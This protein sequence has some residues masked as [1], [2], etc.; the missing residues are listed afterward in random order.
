[1]A[2][3]IILVIAGWLVART[4]LACSAVIVSESMAP[5]L[6]G[7]HIAVTCP[8]CKHETKVGIAEDALQNL[9]AHRPIACQNCGKLVAVPPETPILPG[10]S[11]LV[12][13]NLW[14][15]GLPQRW[16]LIACQDPESSEKIIVKRVVGLPG[17]TVQIIDG[18]VFIDGQIARKSL[19]QQAATAVLVYDADLGGT[20]PC[21][22][23]PQRWIPSL[24]N[25]A[26]S[27][28]DGN[29]FYSGS[30]S[31]T[32]ADR[33]TYH[34]QCRVGGELVAG[35]V[36]DQLA[37]NQWL[38]IRRDAFQPVS[39]L[40]LAFHL[41]R[42]KGVA[43]LKVFIADDY[44][45]TFDYSKQKVFLEAAQLQTEKGENK[46]APIAEAS[47]SLPHPSIPVLISTVDRQIM[48]VVG[49]DVVIKE[50]LAEPISFNAT[51]F[52]LEAMGLDII[53]PRIYRD[54]YYVRPIGIKARWAFDKPVHLGEDEYFILGDNSRVSEDSRTWPKGPAVHRKAIFG[55][56]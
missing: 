41:R 56:P 28:I 27:D 26:W 10:D 23:Q 8:D 24:E 43:C 37:Y 47:C 18:D 53:R 9:E 32:P 30:I 21:N 13:R 54:V 6:L 46:Q 3:A 55:R 15:T 1:M 50:P 31:N 34:H 4:W 19:D 17:E 11:L 14:L 5:A 2:V 7:P 16:D 38:P 12:Q 25:T 36:T 44:V 33:L 29:F 20:D 49:R 52:S 35:P 48:V 22:P 42:V 51:P 40:M 45:V 39:D